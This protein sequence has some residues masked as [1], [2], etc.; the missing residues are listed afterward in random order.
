VKGPLKFSLM[1]PSQPSHRVMSEEEEAEY[2]RRR[3]HW[4][5]RLQPIADACQESERLTAEDYAVLG[6]VFRSPCR[7]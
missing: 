1:L 7:R 4:R 6:T 3:E 2:Q 5:R